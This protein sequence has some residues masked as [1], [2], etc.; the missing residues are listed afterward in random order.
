MRLSSVVQRR[1]KNVPFLIDK[2]RIQNGC[3]NYCAVLTE[4]AHPSPRFQMRTFD[5]FFLKIES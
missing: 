3:Y 4:Q 5:F 1:E 2:R